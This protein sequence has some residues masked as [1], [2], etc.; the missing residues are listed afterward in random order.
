MKAYPSLSLF[1][2]VI[3]RILMF[4]KM[5]KNKGNLSLEEAAEFIA[6]MG[7]D[8]VD[9][10]VREGGYVIP[11][12]VVEK[13]PQAVQALKLKGL[14]VPMITTNVT[15]A[16]KDYAEEVFRTASECGVRYVKLGYWR[17]AGFGRIIS[18]IE[19][20]RKQLNEIYALSQRYNVTATVHTHAGP[21]LSAD[22]ALLYML[23]KEYD[24]EWLGAYID[25][26]H[27]FAESG[28]LGL[29]MRI[30]LLA[31]YIRLVAVKNYRWLRLSDVK[32]GEKTWKLQ[33]MPLS[34]EIVPWPMVFKCLKTLGFNG[35]ISVHSEY[36]ALG[37][38]ELIQQTKED[39]DYTR[40]VL[41]N[42]Q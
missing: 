34:E 3:M 17:Y 42:I 28:P 7:F 32:T 31:P 20:V 11:E 29:E 26:G 4:I 2:A 18:Q 36:E 21:Y 1:G 30:D 5:L 15:D 24:P 10:T 27:M 14:D 40:N 13:L 8:G 9:L 41:K 23:L 6:E 35:C 38:E 25:P 16:G 22:P 12:D 19:E 39:L 33:M 37:F